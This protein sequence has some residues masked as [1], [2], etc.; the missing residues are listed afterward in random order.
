MRWALAAD[1]DEAIDAYAYYGATI[2]IDIGANSTLT[3]AEDDAIYAYGAE[4]LLEA[5]VVISNGILES[6]NGMVKL[7]A[8][9]GKGRRRHHGDR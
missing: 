2:T 5:L 6:G 1:G 8:S 4:R 3:S 7:R 9:S